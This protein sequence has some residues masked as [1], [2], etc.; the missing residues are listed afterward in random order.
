MVTK[1]GDDFACPRDHVQVLEHMVP[2]VSH[3]LVVGW[4]GAEGHFHELWKRA[5]SRSTVLQKVLVV[6]ASEK[7]AAHVDSTLK[8]QMSI[9]GGVRWDWAIEGFST[10]V[11]SA[12]V[13][14]FLG[15]AP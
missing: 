3:L 10:F 14:R 15:T 7:S 12:A 13:K 11:Q 1:T 2:H 4:R 5:A 6:D 8:Q 9:G